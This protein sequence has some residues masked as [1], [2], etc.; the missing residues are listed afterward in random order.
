VEHAVRSTGTAGNILLRSGAEEGQAGTGLAIRA[1]IISGAGSI[2]L[3]ASGDILVDDALAGSAPTIRADAATGTLDLESG[4]EIL[5]EGQ[6]GLVTNN[7]NVRLASPGDI[8]LG[9]I[10][11]GSGT[12]SLVSGGRILDAL[13]DDADSPR[14]INIAAH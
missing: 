4:G 14:S 13:D 2:S 10:D 12:A 6:A 5:F 8:R 3:L 1:D 7:G 9:T 11:A